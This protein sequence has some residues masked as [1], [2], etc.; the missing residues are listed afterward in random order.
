[1]KKIL[2]L[3]L[4]LWL[5]QLSFSQQFIG[6]GW[7]GDTATITAVKMEVTSGV[8]A[9]G[10][11]IFKGYKPSKIR[12]LQLEGLKSV[13]IFI[14]LGGYYKSPDNLELV[15]AKYTLSTDENYM[16]YMF[17]DLYG[18]TGQYFIMNIYLNN[19]DNDKV[20]G[21]IIKTRNE[22]KEELFFTLTD[23]D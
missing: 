12:I 8:G 17:S 13:R 10:K 18:K 3:I 5:H 14:D 21:V 1:M 16:S 7:L 11:T 15:T 22:K 4:G 6:P 9:K 2:L 19:K 23:F 20:T